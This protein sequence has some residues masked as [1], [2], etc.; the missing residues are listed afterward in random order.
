MGCSRAKIRILIRSKPG[1]FIIVDEIGNG[2]LRFALARNE[3]R[4][5]LYLRFSYPGDLDFPE[6]LAVRDEIYQNHGN[7]SKD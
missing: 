6:Y 4:R 3:L 5:F 7:K 2:F 1:K